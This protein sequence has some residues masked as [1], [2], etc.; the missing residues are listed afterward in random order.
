MK[1][2]VPDLNSNL[3]I[4]T[5]RNTIKSKLY[6]LELYHAGEVGRKKVINIFNSTTSNPTVVIQGWEKHYQTF[7][8]HKKVSENYEKITNQEL[9]GEEIKGLCWVLLYI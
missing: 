7:H 2:S 5:L 4:S 9:P 1:I 6:W 8:N 3:L